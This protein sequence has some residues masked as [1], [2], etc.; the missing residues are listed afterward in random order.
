MLPSVERHRYWYVLAAQVFLLF[1]VA[2]MEHHVVLTALFVIALFSI[3]G[4]IILAMWQTSLPRHL[5][6]ASAAVAIVTGA[7]ELVPGFS[8]DVQRVV[9]IVC[10]FAYAV[11]ILIALV[12]IGQHVFTAVRVNANRIVGS[13]CV[14]MLIGMFFAFFDAALGLISSDMFAMDGKGAV[15]S[16]KELRDFMYFSYSTLTTT[17]YGDMVPTHAI[18]RLFAVLEG[19]IGSIY[20][21]IM[22]AWLVGMHV[23]QRHSSQ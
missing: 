3:F 16:I 21:A 5:A 22:V 12:S 11:F 10:C 14:Y 18:S 19:I 13:I 23:T 7:F 4:S 1:M 9:L 2:V 20:L 8:A 17:G 6:I 15:S